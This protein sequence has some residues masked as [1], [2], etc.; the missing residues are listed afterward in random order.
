MKL[1]VV[2]SNRDRLRPEENIGKWFL[3]SIQWQDFNDFELVIADGGSSNYNALQAY[4]GAFK[5]QIPVRLVQYRIGEAFERAKLNNVGIR[6]AKGEYIMT[7]DVDMLFAPKFISTLASFLEPNVMVESRTMYWKPPIVEA[8]YSGKL[9]PYKNLESCKV[10]RIKKQSTAGG[11]QCIHKSSWEMLRGFDEKYIGWGSEDYDLLTRAKI[12]KLKIKWMGESLESIML[13][14]QPH[15]KTSIQIKRDLEYQE[16][17]K[18]ILH[19]IRTHCVNPCGWG[20][21]EG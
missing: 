11:C 17:N 16:E 19:N 12:A 10:G 6:Q 2:A 4:F 20:G 9:D 14:H 21:I 18:K 5:G 7:T 8:I 13:F 3:K 15:A 1:S